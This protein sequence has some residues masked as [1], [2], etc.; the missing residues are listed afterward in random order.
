M[1]L[2]LCPVLAL[3]NLGSIGKDAEKNKD[4]TEPDNEN[5]GEIEVTDKRNDEDERSE[6][7]SEN[8]EKEASSD[9][10]YGDDMHEVDLTD[11]E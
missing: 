7:G 1:T 8:N 2:S 9:S 11:K 3:I 10:D 5:D 6:A 4:D